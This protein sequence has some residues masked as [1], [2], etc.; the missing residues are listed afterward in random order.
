M[1]HFFMLY[2]WAVLGTRACSCIKNVILDQV[3]SLDR[4]HTI[5][6]EVQSFMLVLRNYPLMKQGCTCTTSTA[7]F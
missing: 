4:V 3:L 2:A 6:S 7:T 5:A 1:S